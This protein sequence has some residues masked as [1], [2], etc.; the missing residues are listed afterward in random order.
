MAGLVNCTA[1]LRRVVATP[2]WQRSFTQASGAVKTIK[3]MIPER[4]ASSKG[5]VDAA[6]ATELIRNAVG[7]LSSE[8]DEKQLKQMQR[9]VRKQLQYMN[10]PW[11]IAK[12]VERMLEKDRY[13]EALMLVE[14][15]SIYAGYVVS[16][17]HLIDY[18]FKAGKGKAAVKLFNDV[19]PLSSTY[20]ANPALLKFL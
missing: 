13:R 18:Q 11:K 15:I 16:W 4:D 8:P 2:R 14:A 10:D 1:C 7:D 9:N 3:A 6:T 19:R 12:E 20:T 17:N 5:A